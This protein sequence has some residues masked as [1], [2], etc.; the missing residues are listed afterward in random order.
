MQIYMAPMEGITGHVYRRAH[1]H[2]FGHITR[3][4]TPF[5]TNIGLSRKEYQDMLPENNAGMET[6]P[7][8]LTNRAEVFLELC[9]TLQS[10]GYDEVNLN[11]GCPSATVT[12]KGRGSGFLLYPEKLDA[13]LDEIFAG[14]PLKISV[15][16]RVGYDSEE[17][18]P[19]LLEILN[20]YPF[21]EMIVHPRLREDFYRPGVRMETFAYAVEHTHHPLCYNG[22][23]FSAADYEN[24]REQF[25]QQDCV[26]LG[27]GLITNPGL[28]GELLGE[29]PMSREQLA[30]FLDEVLRGYC[31]EMQGDR[32]VL[33]RLLEMWSYLG[34]MIPDSDKL[35]KKMR[36]AK[37]LSEYEYLAREMLT[38]YEA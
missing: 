23:L 8:I 3:Y 4:F 13:F 21:T 1:Y 31:S 32:N 6:V 7:Q 24:M 38:H 2:T 20:R 33:F 12:A 5:L 36:K 22:D 10:F 27:R 11:I 16:T 28:A 18:W 35:Q 30:T 17:E 9:R 26:M 37:S 19:E 29:E 34:R 15:K 25:P 14:S